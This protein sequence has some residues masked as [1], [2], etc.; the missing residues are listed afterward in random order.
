MRGLFRGIFIIVLIACPLYGQSP[1]PTATPPGDDEV[2]KIS[3]DLIQLD[4]AVTD[5]DGRPIPDLRP[6]EIE[7]YENGER[8]VLTDLI[9]V[10]NVQKE[11]VIGDPGSLPVELPQGPIEPKSI[12]R[13]IALVVDDLSLSFGSTYWVRKALEKFIDEEVQ[14]GDLVA[15]IRT[16]AG[17]GALQ[18][19][20]TDKRMLRAAVAKVKFSMSGSAPVSSFQPIQATLEE[21]KNNT[22]SRGDTR[23]LSDQIER[24]AR[25]R[26]EMEEIRH[27]TFTSGTLGA[28][29]YIIRGMRQLP[30]RKSIVLLS[31]GFS[32][33]RR[34]VN[35]RSFP[36]QSLPEIRALIDRANRASVVINTLDARGVTVP[37]KT[38]ED[39]VFGITDGNIDRRV[40]DRE[41]FI[42][43]T[44]DGLRYLAKETGGVLYGLN[45][46]SAGLRTI[47][48]DQSYYLAAYVPDE[49]TFDPNVRKFN[50]IKVEVTR[51]GAVVRYRS[52]FFAAA[53][54]SDRPPELGTGNER[55]LNA[56]VSPFAVNDISLGM[57]SLFT[58]A[59]EKMFVRTLIY[60]PPASLSFRN[61]ADSKYAATFDLVAMST[62]DNGIPLD[63]IFKKFTITVDNKTYQRYQKRG[64][65][66]N[67]TF[68]IKKE[69]AYQLRVAVRDEATGKIGSA[70]QFIQIPD[71]KKNRLMVTSAALENLTPRQQIEAAAESS[72]DPWTATALRQFKAG[73]V[74]N[75]T[76]SVV[77]VR[78]DSSGNTSL[79]AQSRLYKDEKQIF[80]SSPSQV[81]RKPTDNVLDIL[82]TLNLG[83]DL[84]PGDYILQIDVTDLLSKKKDRTVSQFIQFEIVE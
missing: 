6:D 28:L 13:T 77:N 55:I 67:F 27:R 15:V 78:T 3:T 48:R 84:E 47:M 10:S 20:T 66:Y 21:I 7:I 4:I 29:D 23:D 52:G 36:S 39:D 74:L 43:D 25:A 71:P 44:R 26:Q 49:E 50:E 46:I 45:N 9:F 2:V 38:A 59:S 69:G 64:F 83:S 5:G 60:F 76:F 51:P 8:Q 79:Q 56:L 41:D 53:D 54:R 72:I 17:I 62:G 40:R 34:D 12:H 58:V 65:V 18:Q 33:V 24:Q 63:H 11:A 57:N 14:P 37:G 75:Y 68:P 22:R 42:S 82:G 80:T 61:Q 30:G 73:T 70:S 19:F 31:D 35:G 81:S 16:G 32:L 1:Q